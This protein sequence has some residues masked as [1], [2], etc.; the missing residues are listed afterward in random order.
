MLAALAAAVAALAQPDPSAFVGRVDNTWFP[1]RPG[2]T[3]VYRGSKDGKPSRDVVTVERGTRTIAGVRCTVVHDRLFLDGKLAER[4]TDW[5]AQDRAGNVWYFGEA[6]A[7]LDPSGR[8]AST[9]GSWRTGVDGARPGI[10]MPAHPKVGQRFAQEHYPGH[11]ED[12]F[13]VVRVSAR[14]LLTKEW[15]PLEPGVI[16]HKSYTKGVGMVSE[17]TVRGGS[18]RAVL[19]SLRRS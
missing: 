9:E 12:H 5:Y 7:E 1:L 19:V 11:A 3:W 18:E 10:L 15:T 8:I 13:Q 4:T 17:A 6:T 14:K 16:D 2:T